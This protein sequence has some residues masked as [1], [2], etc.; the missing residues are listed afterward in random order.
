MS[1]ISMIVA[2]VE[3]VCCANKPQLGLCCQKGI[4]A[5]LQFLPGML[6]RHK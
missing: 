3:T 2:E 4:H 6:L 5:I 1:A